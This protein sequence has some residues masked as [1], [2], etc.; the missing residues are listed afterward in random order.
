MR[1]NKINHMDLFTQAANI[2]YTKHIKTQS[3]RGLE[4]INRLINWDSLLSPIESSLSR[5]E[6]GR[7]P[8]SLKLIVKCFILQAIYGLSDPRLEEEIADRRS[9]QIFLDISSGDSIPDETTICRYRELFAKHSLDKE[10]FQSFN[11][12]LGDAGMIL[13]KGTIVD[14]SIKEAYSTHRSKRDQ[15]A[16]FTSRGQKS[17]YGYKAH[18]GIDHQT[19]VIHST[20]FTP[21][22]VHDSDM[23]DQLLTGKEQ[24][25]IADKGYANKKRKR[26]LRDAGVF[27]GILDKGY[28][29]RLLSS[30]Q[31]RRN[32]NLS[33]I[34]SAV[35]RP[36]AFA[37]QIL[38]YDRCR[39]YSL[40]RNRF[41][42]NM[43]ALIYNLR[44]TM[45]LTPCP[46]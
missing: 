26:R 30:K 36:F 18:I 5:Q 13:E 28:R 40:S 7:K 4:M 43:V 27:C 31:Q 39:Y 25:V 8:F 21:A 45:T 2:N 32:M 35:E 29:N 12:Q 15:D 23:F 17:Y 20:E 38:H 10:L 37:K 44:R 3:K 41:Q 42:F 6:R 22:N 1:S 24:V 9:F 33:H 11:H 14:A 34:R 16:G 19:K 46:L